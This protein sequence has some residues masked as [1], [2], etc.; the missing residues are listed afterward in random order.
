MADKAELYCQCSGRPHL[1]MAGQGYACSKAEIANIP[2]V[3]PNLHTSG[4][5]A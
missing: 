5:A 4:G 3:P 2:Q 1:N